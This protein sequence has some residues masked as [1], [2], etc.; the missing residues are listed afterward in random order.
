[1]EFYRKTSNND[2]FYYQIES[3]DY[4]QRFLDYRVQISE[5]TTGTPYIE[6]FTLTSSNVHTEQALSLTTFNAP[7]YNFKLFGRL[8]DN[9]QDE[10]LLL[11]QVLFMPIRAKMLSI[12]SSD[13]YLIIDVPPYQ[14][15][16]PMVARLTG[17]DLKVS[18]TLIVLKIIPFLMRITV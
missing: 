12:T 18:L 5:V 17:K 13:A 10:L 9:L 15:F 2:N 6:N 3:S 4:Q 1:V 8:R 11:E 14:D 7:Q 16:E